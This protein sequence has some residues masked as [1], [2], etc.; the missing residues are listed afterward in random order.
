MGGVV[1]GEEP[2]VIMVPAVLLA[3][4]GAGDNIKVE[5]FSMVIGHP[6]LK[7][8]VHHSSFILNLLL[9]PLVTDDTSDLSR[10]AVIGA[11]MATVSQLRLTSIASRVVHCKIRSTTSDPTKSPFQGH[12]DLKAIKSCW[13]GWLKAKDTRKVK[14]KIYKFYV[15]EKL[16]CKMFEYQIEVPISP[17]TLHQHIEL[18]HSL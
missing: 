9:A 18:Y 14:S 1:V 17:S 13:M 3:G 15:W 6:C 16:A 8:F 5:I 4:N 2:A 7:T 10:T 11:D 12:A